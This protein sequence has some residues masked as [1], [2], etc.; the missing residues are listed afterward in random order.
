MCGIG[1]LIVQADKLS[2]DMSTVALPN[3]K[4]H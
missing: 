1:L 2:A 3:E 4:K